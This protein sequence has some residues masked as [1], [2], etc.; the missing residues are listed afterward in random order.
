MHMQRVI[1]LAGEIKVGRPLCILKN[2]SLN[3][4]EIVILLIRNIKLYKLIQSK[5]S[6]SGLVAQAVM[7]V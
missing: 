6:C 2:I 4:L 1:I 5:R 7:E 3:L